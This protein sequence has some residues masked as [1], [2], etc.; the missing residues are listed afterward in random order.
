MRNLAADWQLLRELIPPAF[1]FMKSEWRWLFP[2]SVTYGL[3]ILIADPTAL[4]AST[5]NDQ[6][7]FIIAATLLLGSVWQLGYLGLV[8]ACLQNER[9][10]RWE[11]LRYGTYLLRYLGISL[12]L[13]L[14]VFVGLLLWAKIWF[15]LAIAWALVAVW[16]SLRLAFF[17]T[18]F[19]LDPEKGLL[20]ALRSS[21]KL[22]QGKLGF[23]AM[24][25]LVSE[26]AVFLAAIP[27]GIGLI[28]ALPFGAALN[29]LALRA[30]AR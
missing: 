3:T 20:S 5:V 4:A 14:F 21:W 25:F 19:A 17:G 18:A 11:L 13:S 29:L 2:V 9:R 26:G 12:A 27:F 1:R 28:W 10:S 6:Q 22:S 30:L 7:I 15:P 24:L 23:I 16:A 8:N